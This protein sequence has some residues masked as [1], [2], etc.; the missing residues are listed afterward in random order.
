M[1]RCGPKC[2]LHPDELKFP[3]CNLDC[4][5]NQA[6]LRAAYIRAK[7]WGYTA[8]AKKA[9]SL[10]KKKSK[11]KSRRNKRSRRKAEVK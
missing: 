5:Y 3:V 4:T 2:F 6:G 9:K 11:R 1:D 7:Q 8:V 10:M